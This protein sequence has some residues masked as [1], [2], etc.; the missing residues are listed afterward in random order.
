[1]ISETSESV[2]SVSLT[3][4]DI[5]DEFTNLNLNH[6]LGEVINLKREIERLNTFKDWR[7]PFLSAT[8]MAEA[9]FYFTKRGDIVRC[10]FCDIEMGNWVEGDD[11][12][13]NHR[14][15]PFIKKLP[16]GNVP[17]VSGESCGYSDYSGYDTCGN[18]A[19]HPYIS[20]ED[21]TVINIPKIINTGHSSMTIPLPDLLVTKP[22]LHATYK[23]IE[24]RLASFATWPISL[25]IKPSEL[26]DAGFFYT[27]KGDMVICFYCDGALKDWMDV[28]IPWEE[29]ARWF[30]KCHYVILIKGR[31]FIDEV[32]QKKSKE[33]KSVIETE[34]FQSKSVSSKEQFQ[35]RSVSSSTDSINKRET[36]NNILCKICYTEEMNIL[37][38]PCGHLATCS[39]CA[40]SLTSCI[41]CR[42]EHSAIMRVFLS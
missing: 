36:V 35:S 34:Q 16:V 11:P 13:I 27:G 30:S 5:L 28:D 1:M 14:H 18:N 9:G 8:Q 15:C 29:H 26:S 10:V 2:E 24:S 23:T 7:V 19:T 4:N 33:D 12:T 3:S 25:K 41:I 42:R 32:R 6:N 39:R 40:I 22:P 21:A 38:F 20:H 31:K 17:L 37:F